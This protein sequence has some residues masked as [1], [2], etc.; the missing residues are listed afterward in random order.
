MCKDIKDKLREA[1]AEGQLPLTC[2]EEEFTWQLLN[3]KD[4]TH[5]TTWSLKAAYDLLQ[6]SFDPI[7][8]GV[9]GQDLL[10]GMVFARK[11]G[12]WDHTGMFTA[13]LR[14]KVLY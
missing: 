3:G 9:S 5:G 12:E 10:H 13:V 7:I 14:H 4:Q 2:G 8:D 11:Q 1:V 6:E